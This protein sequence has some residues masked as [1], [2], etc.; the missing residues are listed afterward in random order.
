MHHR[1]C[2]AGA[3]MGSSYA[4][5]D[6][7]IDAPR[8]VLAYT[9]ALIGHKVDVRERCRF[10]GLRTEGGRVVGVDTSDGPIDTEH[11]VLTGGP[12]L[13]EVGTTAGARVPAGGARHQVVVTAPVTG[14]QRARSAD[15]VRPPLRNLLAARRSRR[16][17]LGY[18]QSRRSRRE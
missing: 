13:A 8:N 6:G 2:A 17:A 3:T 1:H 5:G 18:E 10:T 4:P 9:A 15:G 14:I 16:P 12:K 7:Y 11:V